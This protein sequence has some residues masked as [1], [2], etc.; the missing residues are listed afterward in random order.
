M[1]SRGHIKLLSFFALSSI[2]VGCNGSDSI[3]P[4]PPISPSVIEKEPPA[5]FEIEDSRWVFVKDENMQCMDGSTTGFGF[6]YNPES[7]GLM[8]HMQDGGGCF[9]DISCQNAANRNGFTES[10]FWSSNFRD[11]SLLNTVDPTNPFKNYSHVFIP[12]CSGDVFVGDTS[13][14]FDGLVQQGSNNVKQ[15]FERIAYHMNDS[16]EEVV[17]SG[18]SAGGVG[19]LFNYEHAKETF[20]NKVSGL[21]SDSAP[22]LDD[23]VLT[24]CLQET[25]RTT[26]EFANEFSNE[27]EGCENLDNGGL[28]S[29]YDHLANKYKDDHFGIIGTKQDPVFRIFYSFGVPCADSGLKT[30]DF[31]FANGVD[32]FEARM[33]QFDNVH[34]EFLD[35]PEHALLLNI[36]RRVDSRLAQFLFRFK[37]KLS[38][39][40]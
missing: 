4:E 38:L 14:G 11:I 2:V 19:A 26:W 6:R 16:F 35:T 32:H 29:I 20:G 22:I 23:N 24:P 1:A 27:C 36:Q 39:T 10:D 18:S 7:E 37:E 17:L 9:N 12:Y 34:T 13:S 5:P 25:L 30:S 15:V 21:I 33:S 40:P 28:T 31:D 8:V 3:Q